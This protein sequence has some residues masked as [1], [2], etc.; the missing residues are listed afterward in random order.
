MFYKKNVF[1]SFTKFTE[2]HQYRN[3]FLIKLQA[4]TFS[5]I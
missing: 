5:F 4:Y 1:E 2:Q 3:L